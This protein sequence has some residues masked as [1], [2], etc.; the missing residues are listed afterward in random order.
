M[1]F[2]CRYFWCHGRPIQIRRN[3]KQRV[4]LKQEARPSRAKISALC[5]FKFATIAEGEWAAAH[6]LSPKILLTLVLRS[7]C[8]EHSAP[9]QHAERGFAPSKPICEYRSY[10]YLIRWSLASP[11]HT[12]PPF[13]TQNQRLKRQ[14]PPTKQGVCVMD[15]PFLS[16]YGFL[17]PDPHLRVPSRPHSAGK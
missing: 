16:I 3:R 4:Y 2:V 6:A 12:T 15:K 8:V 5:W 10:V 13:R 7:I 9:F 17:F 14:C 11:P 1:L